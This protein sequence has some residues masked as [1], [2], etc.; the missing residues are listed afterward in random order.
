MQVCRYPVIPESVV[1][2][3]ATGPRETLAR[4]KGPF[5]KYAN[6]A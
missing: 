5:A 2:E 6:E 4:D 1:W 3:L